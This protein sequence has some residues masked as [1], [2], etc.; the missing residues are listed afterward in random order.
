[1]ASDM[2]AHVKQLLGLTDKLTHGLQEGKQVDLVLDFLEPEAS[3]S[4]R[5]AIAL[6]STSFF[7]YGKI[8]TWI[9][10]FLKDKQEAVIVDGNSLSFVPENPVCPMAA[11][12]VLC[13]SYC[14]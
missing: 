11:S 1:M 8:N 6:Y 4:T 5:L 2:D 7:H 3:S 14:T 10:N 13:C 9:V 12:L